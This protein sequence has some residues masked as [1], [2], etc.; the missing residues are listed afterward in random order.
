M[1]WLEQ[2]Q[3]T[4]KD[5][6]W[7]ETFLEELR[8]I[9]SVCWFYLRSICLCANR[10]ICLFVYLAISRIYLVMYPFIDLSIYFL[11]GGTPPPR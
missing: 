11:P 8:F 3:L 6:A 10:A 7:L 4:Q 9:R 5:P 1:A 2:G